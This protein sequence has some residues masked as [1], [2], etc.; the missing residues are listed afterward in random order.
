MRADSA[1]SGSTVIW[2]TT[3]P[4]T[5]SSSTHARWGSSMRFIVEHGQISGSSDT[6]VLSG[7]SWASRLTRWISVPTA[8]VDPVG[9]SARARMM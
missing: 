4:S 7:C 6:T 9:A 8:I 3:R 2:L 1:V 5:S